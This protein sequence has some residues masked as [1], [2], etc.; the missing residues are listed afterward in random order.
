MRGPVDLDRDHDWVPLRR[1]PRTA[2]RRRAPL[3]IEFV[4]GRATHPPSG[5]M[6]GRTSGIEPNGR[7]FLAR[8]EAWVDV[9]PAPRR[10]AHPHRGNALTSA[11]PVGGPCS[12]SLP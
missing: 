2:G 9:V 4:A 1:V 11:A 7:R 3:P 8:L 12:R 6:D 10:S 5:M